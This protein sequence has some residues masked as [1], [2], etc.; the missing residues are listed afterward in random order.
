M[1]FP[2]SLPLHLVLLH[3]WA[4]KLKGTTFKSNYIEAEAQ[5]KSCSG[6]GITPKG[7]GLKLPGGPETFSAHIHF[8]SLVPVPSVPLVLPNSSSMS[9]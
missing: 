8:H 2:F 1:N 3:A 5:T 9:S 6:H 7:A 4:N